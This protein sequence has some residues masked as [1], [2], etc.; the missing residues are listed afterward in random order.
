MEKHFKP[1]CHYIG[2][3]LLILL[4]HVEQEI[5]KDYCKPCEYKDMYDAIYELYNALLQSPVNKVTYDGSSSD[6]L[7]WNLIKS[8]FVEIQSR[9]NTKISTHFLTMSF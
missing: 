7:N 3:L 9:L 6:Q 2:K 1:R 4:E 5:D 8:K